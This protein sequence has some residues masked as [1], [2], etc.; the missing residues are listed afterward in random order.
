MGGPQQDAQRVINRPRKLCPTMTPAETLKREA[1]KAARERLES[2]MLLHL[3]LNGIDAVREFEFWP[4][5]RWRFD[6]AIPQAK[7]AIECQGG[8]RSGGRHTRGD[9]YERDCEKAA[10]AVIAGWRVIP[11]TGDQVQSGK[12]IQWVLA[13]LGIV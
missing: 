1:A 5:R 8:T 12:A 10:H 11:V 7:L 2:V 13:A 3:R 6:F 4:G 9:G